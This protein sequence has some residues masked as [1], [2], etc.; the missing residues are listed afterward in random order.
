MNFSRIPFT[1]T[2][3]TRTASCHANSHS[4]AFFRRNQL[5]AS[6]WAAV[7]E[8]LD[9]TTSLTYLNDC[10][11]FGAIRTGGLMEIQLNSRWELGG[12]V[13]FMAR[14]LERSAETL[15]TLDV[16]CAARPSLAAL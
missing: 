5:D 9:F 1:V 6:G 8:A 16:R 3:T 14:Y 7:A 12:W 15:T 4:H 11:E 10:S 13:P 2:T